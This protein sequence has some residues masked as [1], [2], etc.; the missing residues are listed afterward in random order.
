MSLGYSHSDFC[1]DPVGTVILRAMDGTGGC[2]EAATVVSCVG[3]GL[4][5]LLLLAACGSAQ[6]TR[7]TRACDAARAAA[8]AAQDADCPP[9]TVRATRTKGVSGGLCAQAERAP[10]RIAPCNPGPAIAGPDA[11]D[12][13]W[14]YRPDG[15]DH[16]PYVEFFL[17]E[18]GV[19]V[20][21]Q[22][23]DGNKEGVWTHWEGGQLLGYDVYVDGA[24]DSSGVCR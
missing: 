11:R 1:A 14:C 4:A 19:A 10:V 2:R 5:L 6:Q 8:V 7:A 24:V 13:R 20:T 18:G 9:G 23:S 21:G 3:R 12:A 15:P 22:Y 16:G 17:L